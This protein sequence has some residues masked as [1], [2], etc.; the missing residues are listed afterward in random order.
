M[1]K[2]KL[3]DFEKLDL[4]I[5]TI[6]AVKDHP[7]TNDYLLLIDLGQVEQDMQIVAD[8][9]ESY[10][11]EKLIGKQIIYLDNIMP[12]TIGGIESQGLLLVTHKGGKPVL[13][14]PEKKVLPGVRVA[15]IRD[16][17]SYHHEKV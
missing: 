13:L 14:S 3:K 15:G 1:D 6:K 17:E 4:R 5:G 12:L 8:L 7:E 10:K 9:K 11:K 2:I 16:S